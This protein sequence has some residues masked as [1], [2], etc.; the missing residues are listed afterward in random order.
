MASEHLAEPLGN[1]VDVA[2]V[3]SSG[4]WPQSRYVAWKY[5]SQHPNGFDQTEC[6]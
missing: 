5:G 6:G 4:A 3:V 1:G 2:V